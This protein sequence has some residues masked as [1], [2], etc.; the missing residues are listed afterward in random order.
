MIEFMNAKIIIP[1]L[2]NQGVAAVVEEPAA[3]IPADIM[4]T[5]ALEH[6]ERVQV[7]YM[8]ILSRSEIYAIRQGLGLSQKEFTSLLQLGAKTLSRWEN[9]HWKP[10]RVMNLL[11]KAIR[12]GLITPEYL[13]KMLAPYP[14]E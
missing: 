13:R 4:T 11:L 10:T 3:T 1:C 7:N 8:G 2:D 6:Y 14:K 9:G 12:D 5:D